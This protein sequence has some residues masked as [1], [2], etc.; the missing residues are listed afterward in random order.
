MT[1]RVAVVKFLAT[2]TDKQFVEVVYEADVQ[3]CGM[4]G[5]RF[6]LAEV[7][8][9]KGPADQ[10]WTISFVGLNRYREPWEDD[11]PLAQYGKCA[12]CGSGILSWAKHIVCPVCGNAAYGT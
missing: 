1:D 8:K 10:P 9:D 2:L 4:A 7:S 12:R 11:V 5:T 6:I 3:R